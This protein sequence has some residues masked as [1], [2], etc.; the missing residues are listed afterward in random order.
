MLLT[1]QRDGIICLSAN[2]VGHSVI[3][4]TVFIFISL[5]QLFKVEGDC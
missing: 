2:L 5:Q 1:T 3:S 4:K